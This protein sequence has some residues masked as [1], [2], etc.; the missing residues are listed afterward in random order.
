MRLVVLK[1]FAK[2]LKEKA[3]YGRQRSTRC[4]VSMWKKLTNIMYRLESTFLTLKKCRV[5]NQLGESV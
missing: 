5:D 3:L 4:L 2:L 1:N